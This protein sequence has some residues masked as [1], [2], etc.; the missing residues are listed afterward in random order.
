MPWQQWCDALVSILS[1]G[2]GR[3]RVRR[4]IV[5]RCRQGRHRSLGMATAAANVLQIFGARV[6]VFARASRLCSC[7][8][9]QPDPAVAEQAGVATFV[10]RNHPAQ[11][12][13]ELIMCSQLSESTARLQRDGLELPEE[14]LDCIENIVE[15]ADHHVAG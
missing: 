15:L 8:V 5:W 3:V 2:T 1:E 6:Q 9:C 7:A 13:V 14:V 10:G 12:L 4:D 11:E